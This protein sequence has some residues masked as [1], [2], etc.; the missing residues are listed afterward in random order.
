LVAF[1]DE[2]SA[3]GTNG[4]KYAVNALAAD[5][6]A[7]DCNAL[8]LWIQDVAKA[9][10]FG[11]AQCPLS[12][13]ESKAVTRAAPGA[14]VADVVAQVDAHIAAGGFLPEELVLIMAGTWDVLDLYA[15]YPARPRDEL[16]AEVRARGTRVAE[17]VNRMVGLG[18]RVVVA[19]I[20]DMGLSPFGVAQGTER[21]QLLT[22]L[23][24]ALNGRIRV[25]IVN[26]G[27]LVG[28]VLADEFVQVAAR[29]PGYFGLSNSAT[30]ACT[31]ALPGCTTQTLVPDAVA[32][33]YLWADSR[34]FSAGGHRQLGA[35]A[36]ARAT[37][38]PF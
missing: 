36:V 32:G 29:A 33:S 26:D 35:L 21:A 3:L 20:P 9:F 25:N 4:R 16:I 30:P 8:P 2:A 22:D 10:N 5:G 15:Q 28:L 23:S 31:A 37:L 12:G 14:R 24:A 11:Y 27:R 34:W 18:A 6:Q 13:G 38:N 19:T 7:L 17:Q 1:G